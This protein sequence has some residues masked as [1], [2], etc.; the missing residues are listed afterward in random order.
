[1]GEIQLNGI[2]MSYDKKINVIEGLDL[3]IPDG[4]FTVLVGP[5]GCGK[6]TT[7]NMIAGLEHPSSGDITISGRSMKGVEPGERNIAMVFQN[8][9]LYP[10]MTVWDN[11][12]FGLIN[13]KVPE[14]VRKE[15]IT[16]V[17]ETVGLQ[18]FSK[19]RPAQ[20]SGGQRQRVALARALV[21]EPDAFLLDEPLSNLDAKLRA[22]M[23]QELIQLHQ[24]LGTTFV[25][26]THDQVEAMSMGTLIVLFD[27]GKIMAAGNPQEV[28]NDPPNLFTAGFIGTPS[29]NFLNGSLMNYSGTI[30]VRPERLM[31]DSPPGEEAFQF[32]SEIL[33]KENLGAE[34]IYTL[35]FED[36]TLSVKSHSQFDYEVGDTV[37]LSALKKHVFAFDG[38]DERD[39]AWERS[40]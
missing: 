26:V 15:R 18:E 8:Y 14:N 35:K 25:Y 37:R 32:D 4:S 29:M 23:R 5:S 34:V 6:S 19:K 20:L 3:T 36:Q 11:I 2:T 38:K 17:I 28:Y 40:L 39:Y 9:A 27:K 30:G 7:L 12:E 24:R 22:Q 16:E 13:N 31:I 1:M 33:S 10:T 21:K